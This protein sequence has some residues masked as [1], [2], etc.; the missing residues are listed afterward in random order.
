MADSTPYSNERFSVLP[1]TA[2]VT[3]NDS[4]C[5]SIASTRAAGHLTPDGNEVEIAG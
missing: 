3:A 4:N 5:I 2:V 1:L